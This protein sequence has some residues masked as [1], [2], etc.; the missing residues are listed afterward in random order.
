MDRLAD[1]LERRPR[2]VA[3][4]A[5]LSLRLA[6]QDVTRVL[7]RLDVVVRLITKGELD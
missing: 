4:L 6:A 7:G 3:H 1:D 5:A 2:L